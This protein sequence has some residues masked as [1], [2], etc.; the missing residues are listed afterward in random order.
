MAFKDILLTLTS[1]PDPTPARCRGCG[2]IAATLRRAPYRSRLRGA[3]SGSR[4]FPFRLD[5]QHSR[6]HRGRSR[7]EPQEREGHARRIR[8]SR[9]Q[10]WRFCTR[11]NWKNARPSSPGPPGRVCAASRS[12]HRAG[13]GKLRSM[14]RGSPHLRI[15]PADP[16]LARKAS[17]TPVRTGN[18]RRRLGFQPRRGPRGFR[19]ACRCSKRPGRCASSP[20]STKRIWIPSI[21]P[22]NWP[23]TWR[24]TASMW[25]WTRSTPT[26]EPI[27]EVLEAYTA[28]A[29]GRRSRDGRL[30]PRAMARIHPRRR[31][32]EPAVQAAAADP[33]FALTA[34]RF[35]ARRDDQMAQN[36][37]RD[38][39]R[40]QLKVPPGQ[41]R[42]RTRKRRGDLAAF[43]ARLRPEVFRGFSRVELRRNSKLLLATLLITD[44]DALV[45]PDEFGLSEP[46]FRRFAEPAGSS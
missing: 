9:R 15:G 17:R 33:V 13:A 22:K 26:A 34:D 20:S 3:C 2:F 19:R 4:P 24:A 38:D 32:Q 16:R 45:G 30:W 36:T 5:C 18:R 42:H 37:S 21:P 10:G 28:F 23:R 6:H 8:R 11:P 39:S 12:H 25:C 40:P 35:H 27:G 14:V 31:D 29:S 43:E 1:Y 41:P 7:K 46:A 44:D